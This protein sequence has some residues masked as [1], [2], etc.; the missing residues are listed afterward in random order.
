MTMYM[1]MY[2]ALFDERY[3]PVML[4]SIGKAKEEGH[5]S[6]RLPSEQITFWR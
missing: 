1:T 5:E 2:A 4:L 6:V 3:V